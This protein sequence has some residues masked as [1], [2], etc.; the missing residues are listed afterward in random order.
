MTTG[1]KPLPAL[2]KGQ[3]W[4]TDNVYIQVWHIGKRLIDYKMMKQLRQ[5]AVR[6]QTTAIETLKEYLTF[7]SAVLVNASRA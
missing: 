7:H 6:T 5:K 2:V 3:L 4:K 1:T